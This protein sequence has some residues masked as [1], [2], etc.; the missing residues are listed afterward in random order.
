MWG[1]YIME[2]TN[3]IL[4][5]NLSTMILLFIDIYTAEN[6]KD[7]IFRHIDQINNFLEQYLKRKLES[8]KNNTS[9]RINLI[10][11]FTSAITNVETLNKENIDVTEENLIEFS[12]T[13]ENVIKAAKVLKLTT[14]ALL[15][16]F[17]QKSY[18]VTELQEL[19]KQKEISIIEKIN[20]L[21]NDKSFDLK[22]PTNVA[23]LMKQFNACRLTLLLKED[24]K[25]IQNILTLLDRM[26]AK[27]QSMY[28]ASLDPEN[29]VE[30]DDDINEIISELHAALQSALPAALPPDPVVG[31]G[32]KVMQLK[33]TDNI[34]FYDDDWRRVVK[35]FREKLPYV[36]TMYV[37]ARQPLPMLHG[38][39]P[40]FYPK[41]F[42]QHY[43]NNK[44]GQAMVNSLTLKD[45]ENLY[46]ASLFGTAK[47]L[48]LSDVATILRWAKGTANGTAKGAEPNATAKEPRAILFDWDYTLS[49]GTGIDLPNLA[50]MRTWN[51][52]RYKNK[53]HPKFTPKEVAQYFAGSQSRFL[54]L[55]HM[56]AELHK[57]QVECFI[58]TNNGW[59]SHAVKRSSNFTYFASIVHAM[60]PLMPADNI[61]Y[62]NRDK[63]K[64]FKKNK[65]FMKFYRRSK[66]RHLATLKRVTKR[67]RRTRRKSKK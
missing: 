60:D 18:N 24:T 19:S 48:T 46:V 63:V 35:E 2:A 61:I 12:G 66:I 3:Y 52:T 31:G 10:D 30:N 32:G 56:F 42:H 16:P 26:Y 28:F 51:M 27:L 55:K 11:F 53:Y 62:G 43:K 59:A 37:S 39:H 44:F 58:F 29:T 4:Q 15:D 38:K 49:I 23:H 45:P 54:A 20:T 21:I 50:K 6:V 8:L 1:V 65:T 14:L 41:V 57:Q 7:K 34:V 33:P 64:T 67:T 13:I 17:D 22:Y 5:S 40:F 9:E 25:D 47:G 36:K